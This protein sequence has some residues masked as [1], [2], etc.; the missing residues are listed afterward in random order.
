MTHETEG[1]M[2]VRRAREAVTACSERENELRRQLAD[3]V[4]STRSAREKFERVFLE[5]EAREAARRKEQN[6]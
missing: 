4:R 1:Q 5:E 6:R 3:A 2:I